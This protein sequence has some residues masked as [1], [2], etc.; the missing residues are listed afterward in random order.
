MRDNDAASDEERPGRVPQAGDDSG[1]DHDV[2]PQY[3]ADAISDAGRPRWMPSI[4]DDSKRDCAVSLQHGDDMPMEAERARWMPLPEDDPNCDYEV[5]YHDSAM[6][7]PP[8]AGLAATGPRRSPGLRG[9]SS[10]LIH[11]HES[12]RETLTP[13]PPPPPLSCTP[14]RG[15]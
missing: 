8:S 13:P 1:C 14:Q 2:T 12:A 11:S 3:N 7:P 9:P 6:D 4:E 5:V 15:V 10:P